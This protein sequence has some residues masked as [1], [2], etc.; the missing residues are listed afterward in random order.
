MKVLVVSS[1]VVP[2]AKTGG[3]ADVI[4]AFPKFLKKFDV[5]VR[6]VLPK[7]GMTDEKKF[8][9]VKTSIDLKI[10]IGKRNEKVSVL[11]SELDVPDKRFG[12]VPVYFIKHDGYYNRNGLYGTL[13][14][15]FSD[16]D[17]RFMLFCR[18][19]IEFVK[20]LGWA[21]D[22][23]HVNDW[24]A[25]LIPV[26][27]KTLY[28]NDVFFKHTKTIFT[29]HNIAYQGMFPKEAIN[30]AGLPWK[31]FTPERL[32]YYG[33]INY[34][35]SG[36]VYS[37]CITTVSPTYALQIQDSNEFGRG[38][39]GVLRS[40]RKDLYGIINGL[41]Y[42]DWDPEKD[43]F[44]AEKYS[45]NLLEGKLRCK[46]DLQ[47]QTG[48]P[49]R[50]DVPLLGMVSR[51]DSQKGFDLLVDI[52]DS[53][54]KHEL[55]IVLLGTGDKTYHDLLSRK[56]KKYKRQFS[57]NLKFDNGLAHKIYAGSD[58]FLMPS[59]FEPCGLG[60]MISI[61]YYTVPIVMKTG[62]LADTITN[63][64]E[65]SLNG[66]G[67]VFNRYNSTSF[68]N[69]LLKAVKIYK[70]QKLLKKLLSNLSTNDFSWENSIKQYY[71]LYKNVLQK[72]AGVSLNSDLY[73]HPKN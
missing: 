36:L 67:I 3:L 43:P 33:K 59:K 57:L 6:V 12:N 66:N 53:L 27:L 35:K 71:N 38:M 17:E 26:Y 8:N 50:G 32:E 42:A 72:D 28:K 4:G 52:I 23:I 63:F 68:F 2:F 46:M 62:G 51:I 9:L 55:Q 58:F 14:G 45:Y 56:A 47:R 1:E 11:Q 24:Q 54:L 30:K 13:E 34:L 49:Q 37:D 65:K 15:D 40:R 21:P 10:P 16:N 18:A 7:Y 20:K 5:D 61:R 60:Q 22:I 25:G 48:L 29:I 73:A 41:D 19:A 39:E 31:H 69:A 44:I 70:T 64:S